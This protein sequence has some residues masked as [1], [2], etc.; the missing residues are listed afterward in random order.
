MQRL[1]FAFLVISG[2]VS[3]SDDTTADQQDS[4]STSYVE[5]QEFGVNGAEDAWY[6]ITSTMNGQF[7]DVC[8]DTFCEGD[9][10]NITPLRLFCSVTS[11][12]GNIH[13]CAWTFTASQHE[14][15]PKSAAVAIDAVTY[16]CHFKPATTGTKLIA[17]LQGSTDPLHLALP[18]MGSVYD[19]LGDC[20]AHPI[21]ATPITI[22]TGTT[23]VD[24]ADYYAAPVRWDTAVTNLK[25]GFDD[26]CGDTFCGSDYSDVQALDLGCSVTKSTGN[27]KNC[28]W[29]FGGSFTTIN[30]NGT[31]AL[32]SKT[33]SCPVAVHGTLAQMLAV[34]ANPGDTSNAI[35]RALPGGTSA[36]DSVAGCV[37]R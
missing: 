5:I 24:A 9:F 15:D 3:A 11:K 2:C 35:Q 34:L 28:V 6:S 1:A 16:Q 19:T 20:F 26:V 21:G 4:S 18:G 37:T 36:Y 8:G 31:L 22:G 32:T 25:A 12:V 17:L 10:S 29:N 27:V 23:Y 13:D 33:W 14:I 7:N 30:K